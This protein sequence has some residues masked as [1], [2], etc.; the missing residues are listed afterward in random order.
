VQN[1]NVSEFVGRQAYLRLA[2]ADVQ[3]QEYD[4]SR[5]SPSGMPS[6][7]LLYGNFH[8]GR[9]CQPKHGIQRDLLA[10]G[11]LLA[12]ERPPKVDMLTQVFLRHA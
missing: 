9:A 1:N 7:D 12:L 6:A 11:Q 2:Q 10:A 3:V 5:S 4:G 8:A